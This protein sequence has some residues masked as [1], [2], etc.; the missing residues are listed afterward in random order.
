MP[1]RRSQ[2]IFLVLA[3]LFLVSTLEACGTP[4]QQGR[5][6]AVLPSWPATEI[7]SITPTLTPLPPSTL[8]PT[9]TLQPS[10]TPFDTATPQP[11]GT[12]LPPFNATPFAYKDVDGKRVDDSYV[13]ISEHSLRPSGGTLSFSGFVAFK[14]LDRGIHRQTLRLLEKD[15]TL[16]TLR[17]SHRFGMEEKEVWLILTGVWGI[18]VPFN[19]AGADG[20]ANISLAELKAKDAFDPTEMHNDWSTSPAKRAPNYS[21]ISLTDLE[22]LLREM[23]QKSLILAENP[24]LFPADSWHQ[25]KLNMV[26]V[27]SQAARFHW[28]FNINDFNI[29]VGQNA[30]ADLWSDTLLKGAPLPEN[31]A[32]PFYFAA[33]NL[34]LVQ[35]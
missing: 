7:P 20:S 28:L 13:A 14:L 18:N 30:N 16:Y 22:A 21:T 25:V 35:P 2:K 9:T 23:P 31:V 15:L 10:I 6:T 8:T 11:T 26:S 3:I 19:E 32:D 4:A 17:V 1:Q 29:I 27:S 12:A 24:I 34:V 33:D 5:P